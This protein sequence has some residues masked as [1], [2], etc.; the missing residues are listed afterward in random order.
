LHA[1]NV[2]GFVFPRYR[3]D[4]REGG[5]SSNSLL[6]AG[7]SRALFLF[8]G[9]ESFACS[10]SE[11]LCVFD[12]SHEACEYRNGM[13]AGVLRLRVFD[14]PENFH[15]LMRVPSNKALFQ[16]SPWNHTVARDLSYPPVD[17]DDRNHSSWLFAKS[18]QLRDGRFSATSSDLREFGFKES[19]NSFFS[20]L[21][22]L[23][24]CSPS[25]NQQRSQL[26]LMVFLIK[27]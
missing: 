7:P 3:G 5:S 21:T 1:L 17:E 11:K 19:S 14:K 16:N 15:M 27:R 20:T 10:I 2:G 9:P 6:L 4:R 13:H 22:I 8:K 26:V 12:N 25:L 18:Q 24:N 23:K